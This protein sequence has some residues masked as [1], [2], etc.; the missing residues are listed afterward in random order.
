MALSQQFM[1]RRR[2]RKRGKKIMNLLENPLNIGCLA[3]VMQSA[4][5]MFGGSHTWSSKM[6]E[7]LF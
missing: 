7:Q 6:E 5:E 4:M 1:M 3:S 2:L